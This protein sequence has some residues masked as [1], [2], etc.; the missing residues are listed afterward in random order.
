MFWLDVTTACQTVQ[1]PDET[2]CHPHSVPAH[3]CRWGGSPLIDQLVSKHRPSCLWNHRSTLWFAAFISAPASFYTMGEREHLVYQAKLAEQAERYDGKWNFSS[4]RDWLDT[5]F[6][7]AKAN[8][9]SL[10]Q[11]RLWQAKLQMQVGLQKYK[12]STTRSLTQHM[13]CCDFEI[14]VMLY[15]KHVPWGFFFSPYFNIFERR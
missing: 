3:S 4:G 14:S 11:C 10:A 8:G 12:C 7:S 15:K 2:G 5:F 6:F 9:A 13:T 1:Y